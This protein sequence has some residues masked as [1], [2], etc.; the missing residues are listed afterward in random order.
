MTDAARFLENASV[1][2]VLQLYVALG[3][4]PEAQREFF[5]RIGGEAG[6]RMLERWMQEPRM[7]RMVLDIVVRLQGVANDVGAPP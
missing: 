2:A 4:D 7:R 6:R 1:E 3:D 5:A